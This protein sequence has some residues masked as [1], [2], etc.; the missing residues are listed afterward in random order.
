MKSLLALLL[1]I[2]SLSWGETE[3][4]KCFFDYEGK[5]EEEGRGKFWGFYR[6]FE[7]DLKKKIMIAG[8]NVFFIKSITPKEIVAVY[9]ETGSS[10]SFDTRKYE[11]IFLDRFTLKMTS[12]K[13]G[14]IN[15]LQSI[16]ETKH[17][18]KATLKDEI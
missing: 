6:L 18:C 1:L 9:D 7:I 4:L 8:R 13:Y 15:N 2:P 16:E 12:K 3:F 5:T 11:E 17:N 14:T 10:V